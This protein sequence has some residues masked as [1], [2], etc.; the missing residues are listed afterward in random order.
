MNSPIVIVIG[1][2]FN[3]TLGLVRSLGQ[4]G[5]R[6]ILFLVGYDRLYVSKSRYLYKTIAVES[7]NDCESK[8]K[9]FAESYGESFLICTND[10]AAKWVD[11]N[12][13]WLSKYF[14]TPMRGSSIGSLFDKPIQCELASQFG[15]R[16]PKSTIYTDENTFPTGLSYPLL[17]KPA[18]SNFGEKSDIH[19]CNNRGEALKA[20][21][22][23]STCHT[24]IVQEFIEKE[25]EINLIGV[26]TGKGVVIPGGIKKLRHYPTIYSPCSFGVFMSTE[27]LGID[28][29]PIERMVESIGYHG[30][31]SVEFLHKDDKN[32]FLEINFR[33]DGLAYAA[34]TAG[35]NLLKM[36]IN[37]RPE[38]Y[39]VKETYMMDLSTDYCH[40]KDGQLSRLVWLKD[41]LRTGCQLNFNWR[42]PMPT[43]AYYKKK[44]LK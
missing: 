29:R 12:E 39:D 5:A 1:D 7:F 25:F 24:F 30:P 44:L 23:E 2:S 37:G 32:F 6:V 27:K 22:V 31:F 10:K 21:S 14:K 16:V 34:T 38:Q 17:M 40:V 8:I 13:M 11:D 26:S 33:H 19:I 43:L 20:L 3:N 35:T 36:Y 9:E 41:F 18:N 15:I 4:G 28:P 42:D